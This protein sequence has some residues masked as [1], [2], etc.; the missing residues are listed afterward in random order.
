MLPAMRHCKSSAAHGLVVFCR[1][2]LANLGM[3]A[4]SFSVES[5]TFNVMVT[6]AEELIKQYL[7]GGKPVEP[8]GL[9]GLLAD[10]ALYCV[11]GEE[12]EEGMRR[13]HER[14]VQQAGLLLAT[15]PV[16]VAAEL[17]QHLQRCG[18]EPQLSALQQHTLVLEMVMVCSRKL[19]LSHMQDGW[20]QQAQQHLA[21]A[22]QAC[23]QLVELH[24][25]DAGFKL[26]LGSISSH[27]RPP[28]P[29]AM[30]E[31]RA[32]FAAAD[33][34]TG[35]LAAA[36]RKCLAVLCN[37]VCGSCTGSKTA[38]CSAFLMTTL[39]TPHADH[40]T[41][42]T[43]GL[44]LVHC[45]TSGLE[46][47]TWS[48]AEVQHLLERAEHHDRLCKAW[49]P[50]ALSNK[51]QV[52]HAQA[53]VGQEVAKRPGATTLPVSFGMPDVA[54]STHLGNLDSQLCSYCNQHVHQLKRCSACKRVGG[55]QLGPLSGCWQ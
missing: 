35:E 55:A 43:A 45:L 39:P 7:Q 34:S 38:P 20:E 13:Q 2:L 1:F 27:M 24:P 12:T 33:T 46:G 31:L 25:A 14:C 37:R 54:N 6:A 21:A 10:T 22:V 42:A 53:M 16:S 47:S 30:P 41:A 5:P 4:C 3:P 8:L 52:E 32:S 19:A 51:R 17:E 44:N 15:W 23:S 11:G 50:V 28:G 40:W 9:L 29:M 36:S 49:L 18:F 26:L 48:V